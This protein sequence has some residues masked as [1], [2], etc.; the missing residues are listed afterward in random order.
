MT[1]REKM[2]QI[3]LFKGY[4]NNIFNAVLIQRP[5]SSIQWNE[6]IAPEF[7]KIEDLL[8]KLLEKL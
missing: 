5:I 3:T 4:F 7:R 8:S 2:R 6:K 1:I